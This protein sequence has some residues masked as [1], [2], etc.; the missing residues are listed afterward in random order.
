MDD[1]AQAFWQRYCDTL[2]PA[3]QRAAPSHDPWSFG[4]SQDMADQLGALVRDGIKTATSVLMYEIESGA[5]WAGQV[6]DIELVTDWAGDPL[7]IIELTEVRR[8]P[9]HA[10]DESFAHDYGE[11][12]RTL[13]WWR[14]ALWSY[15]SRRCQ[16]LGRVPDEN[17]LLECTRFRLLYPPARFLTAA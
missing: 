3:L 14:Q 6:G 9:F 4:D 13:A 11:G 10:V 7:C 15:Y 17:M 5:D 2:E 8:I 12:E 16:L 1:R